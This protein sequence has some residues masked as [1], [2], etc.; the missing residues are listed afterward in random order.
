MRLCTCKA[1]RLDVGE[2]IVFGIISGPSEL[3]RLGKAGPDTDA[4]RAASCPRRTPAPFGFWNAPG[5]LGGGSSSN[6]DLSRFVNA[7][8][9]AAAQ[10][11]SPDRDKHGLLQKAFGD[12]GSLGKLFG[13]I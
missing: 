1:R 5:M 3:V 9:G 10:N 2:V 7:L 6:W 12:L 8:R 13:F 4:D 11:Q